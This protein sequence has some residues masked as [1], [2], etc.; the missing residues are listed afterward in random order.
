MF[1]RTSIASC[2]GK[3][4]G[5][6]LPEINIGDFIQYI[7]H[8]QD[9]GTDTDGAGQPIPDFVTVASYWASVVSVSGGETSQAVEQTALVKYEI[10][11]RFTGTVKPYDRFVYRGQNLNV[12][13]V[14]NFQERSVF[15]IINATLL[16]DG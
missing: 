2:P 6:T 13:L 3:S 10:T 8:Q 1:G 5:G 7:D 12:E 9:Q 14:R 11:L 16:A 4:G 15:Y